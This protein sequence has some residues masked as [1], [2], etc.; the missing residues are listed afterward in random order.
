MDKKRK[1]G[2]SMKHGEVDRRSEEILTIGLQAPE[3]PNLS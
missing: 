1:K 3:L 2:E